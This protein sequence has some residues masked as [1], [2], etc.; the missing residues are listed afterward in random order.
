M[1]RGCWLPTHAATVALAV[2]HR[3]FAEIPSVTW[4]LVSRGVAMA[5]FGSGHTVLDGN[6]TPDS[7]K[8]A[9][10]PRTGAI[11]AML[12]VVLV[13]GG[14]G[15]DE[16]R[17]PADLVEDAGPDGA[18][19]EVDARADPS[20]EAAVAPK[21]EPSEG[22][23]ADAEPVRLGERFG[24]CSG[25]QALWDA[26]DQARAETEAAAVAHEAAVRVYEA[27]TDDLDR[28]EAG[29][30]A[31]DA[32]TEYVFAAGDYGKIRWRA[33]GLIFSYE[34][35]V[36]GGGVEDATLQVALD[37]AVEAYRAGAAA[38]TVAAF[39][40]AHE[41][42]ETATRVSAVANSDSD[43]PAQAV[44]A[45]ESESA[46]LDASRGWFK[47][48]EALHDAVEA[49]KDAEDAADAT[50]AAVAAA[51]T[52]AGDAEDAA[53]AISR[54]AQG[55]G[56]WEAMT[57]DIQAHL[58]AARSAAETT[59][60]FTVE[61]FDARIATEAA[62]E[63]ARTAVR[64]S[65]AARALAQ[66]SGATEGAEAYWDMGARGLSARQDAEYRAS[67]AASIVGPTDGYVVQAATVEEAA[68]HAAQVFASVDDRGV[69]AFKESLQKS[70]R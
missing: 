69:A 61:A 20:S 2:Q 37:R 59:A 27:A 42:T 23:V 44:E 25:V 12:V 13:A 6:S 14:C 57:T 18:V 3:G 4:P 29:E 17:A 47:A 58:T 55:D 31:Q 32:Y 30:A 63:A 48:T 60:S 64:A 68:W 46:P 35:I 8:G 54:A 9:T 33:A 67:V 10:M 66:Q 22:T 28:A 1:E 11:L 70:C 21:A 43:E 56:D 5:P 15:G 53:R 52:A 65:E 41:A 45:P 40:F 34:A 38:D 7:P 51:R 50:M 62:A 36:P 19:T 26:Q 39:D 24:W 16:E 49:A